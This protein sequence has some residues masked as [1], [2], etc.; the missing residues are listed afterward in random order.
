MENYIKSKTLETK[1]NLR[2][3]A[4]GCEYRRLGDAPAS[5]C[6]LPDIFHLSLKIVR[7]RRRSTNCTGIGI[8]NGIVGAIFFCEMSTV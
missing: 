1:G 5:G 8:D 6:N 3:T 2:S 4:N 7:P